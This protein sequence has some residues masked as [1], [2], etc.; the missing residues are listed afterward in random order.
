VLVHASRRLAA[1]LSAV[2]ILSGSAAAQASI[3]PTFGVSGGL[4]IPTGSFG[5]SYSSGYDIGVL[6]G[7]KPAAS[8]IGL[9]FEGAYQR[10]D[11]K[12]SNTLGI[13][14]NII[15]GTANAVIGRPAA[16]GSISPYLIGGIGIY[17]VKVTASQAPNNSSDTK[18]GLNIGAG[19]DLPLSGVAVFLEARYHYILLN[20]GDAFGGAS[21]LGVVPIVVG[22][23]F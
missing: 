16:A 13:H 5:Q 1:A 15:S 17:N 7:I 4:A 18:F 21:N 14:T 22:V 20:S 19:I 10:Y 23:R 8:P 3:R 9:R 6:L 2:A 12:G 11:L